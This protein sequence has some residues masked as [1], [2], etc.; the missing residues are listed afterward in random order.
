M[1]RLILLSLISFATATVLFADAA[2]DWQSILALDAGPQRKPSG[3]E[4]ALLTARNHLLLQKRALK[5]FLARYPQDEQAPRAKL[6]LAGIL[7]TE[8][9]MDRDPGTIRGALKMLEA[10]ESDPATP[11]AVR[12]DAAFRRVSIVMQSQDASTRKGMEAVV[13]AA[14]GFAAGF[15]SDPRAPRL[16]V[17]AA[18]VC[19]SRPEIKA[20]LLDEASALSPED[21]LRRRIADDKKR[22]ALLGKPFE[23]SLPGIKSG[24]VDTRNL[25]GE[26]V[27]VVFWATDAPQS[28]IW[29]RDFAVTWLR[30]GARSP[31][32]VAISLDASKKTATAMA[33]ELPPQWLVAYEPGGWM[34]PTA[35]RLGINAL[36]TVWGVNRVGVLVSLNAKTGWEALA[37]SEK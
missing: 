8:G 12:A 31:R 18:T 24:A 23:L 32:V 19:D 20:A 27:V 10:L 37:A 7:A 15:P 36:P 4:E 11:P 29:L 14:R 3:R 9:N 5:G 21:A 28:M 35:R 2:S 17:E 33:A 6:R 13:A 16:L 25:L 1:N 26:P 34:S 22:L 30:K